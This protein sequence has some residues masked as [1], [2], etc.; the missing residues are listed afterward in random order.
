MESAYFVIED[1]LFMT[2][3]M[4]QARQGVRQLSVFGS[5]TRQSFEYRD[6]EMMKCSMHS[7]N[8]G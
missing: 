1:T 8:I 5:K 7:L 4:S 2:D 3:R 6:I